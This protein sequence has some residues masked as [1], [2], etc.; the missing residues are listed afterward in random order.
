VARKR[1]DQTPIPVPLDVCHRIGRK[2]REG[3]FVGGSLDVIQA[4]L[5]T[6]QCGVVGRA[7]LLALGYTR[8]EIDARVAAGRLINLYR[9]VY[10]V[11]HEAVSDRGRMTAALLAAGPDAALSHR[12]A[13]FLWKLIP[14]M[15]PFAE[16]TC[17]HRRPRNRRGLT[18]HEAKTLDTTR[19]HGL[20]VTTPLQTVRQLHG[21]EAD[22]ARAE[23][24]VLGL[25][26]RS[27]D[28]HAEPT[29]SELEDRFLPVLRAAGLPKPV[30]G[31]RVL[32]R[33]VDFHWPDQGVIV[34]TDGWGAHGHRAVFE[35]DRARDA[36]LQAAGLVVVRFTWRQVVGE[37]VK[38]VVQLAQILAFR[39]RPDERQSS[40]VSRRPV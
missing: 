35:D 6:R 32:G 23:A 34:E 10:A 9:G 14:S 1:R 18:I 12:T 15:P 19:R 16:V 40:G 38:V 24:L 22:R 37:T 29:R 26:P 25:I 21:P 13:A 20:H 4:R 39:I 28:D 31:D 2:R 3:E 11:G 17:T 36:A 33:I 7:Q 5:A 30:V 8:R 27:A